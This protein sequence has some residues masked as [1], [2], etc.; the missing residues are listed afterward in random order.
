[1]NIIKVG[2]NAYG[3]GASL[4]GCVNDILDFEEKSKLM[5]APPTVTY[6]LFDKDATGKNIRKVFD[7]AV[8]ASMFSTKDARRSPSTVIFQ[9]SGHGTYI[10]DKNKDEKSGIDGAIVPVDYSKNGVILDDEIGRFAD[11]LKPA[12]LIILL[13]SCFAGQA[14]RFGFIPNG[15]KRM[16]GFSTPRFL[17]V[18]GTPKNTTLANYDPTKFLDINFE[19]SVLVATSCPDETSADA[20]I[21]SKYRGAGTYSL[22]LAW[23]ALGKSAD[24][25]KIQEWA[26]NWL[27]ANGYAQRIMLGGTIANL[28][29]PFMT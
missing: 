16:M 2:I 15:V 12:K 1:M 17:R 24:Y 18:K 26:N 9:Y 3:G 14:Q 25:F 22:M 19:T 5:L 11:R 6:R 21:G 7:E 4:Q 13:D 23:L 27:R 8:K 20:F 10:K 28:K 29:L